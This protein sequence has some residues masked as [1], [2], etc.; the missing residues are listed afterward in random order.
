MPVHDRK[1]VFFSLFLL[2]TIY[3]WKILFLC[4]EIFIVFFCVFYLHLVWPLH[5]RYMYLR[6]KKKKKP[7]SGYSFACLHLQYFALLQWIF[8]HCWLLMKAGWTIEKLYTQKMLKDVY[9]LG[10]IMKYLLSDSFF[11]RSA[12]LKINLRRKITLLICTY[13]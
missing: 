11:S 13:S 7:L 8:V 10:Q 4:N 5:K 2:N 3:T 1:V 12:I 6:L 9:T